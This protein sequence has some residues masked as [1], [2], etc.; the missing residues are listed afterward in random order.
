[1]EEGIEVLVPLLNGETVTAK[2]DWFELQEARLRLEPYNEEGIEMAGEPG[3]ANRC[4]G[5]R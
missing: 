3:V 1:M 5:G 4:K 2:T